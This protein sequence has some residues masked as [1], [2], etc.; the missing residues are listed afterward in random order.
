MSSAIAEK[1]IYQK[2]NLLNPL[3][4]QEV[5]DFIEFLLRRKPVPE[6]DKKQVLLNIS[7]WSEEDIQ[8]IEDVRF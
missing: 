1:Q 3:Q 5:D 2:L 7:V 4:R 8:A 6:I